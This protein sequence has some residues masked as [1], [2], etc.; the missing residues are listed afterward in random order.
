MQSLNLLLGN[1]ARLALDPFIFGLG[2]LCPQLV[3]GGVIAARVLGLT[4]IGP[5]K[6]DSGLV[7]DVW[8][9]GLILITLGSP[10]SVGALLKDLLRLWNDPG[11][12]VGGARWI[13]IRSA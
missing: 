7:E 11:T 4:M 1:P 2:R 5:K 9:A 12:L 10:G 8:L 3:S 6:V 13:K